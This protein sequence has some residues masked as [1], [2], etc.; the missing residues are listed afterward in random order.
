MAWE[1]F[2]R[3]GV[4][5]ITGDQP[6]DELA[7]ALAEIAK[8]YEER[9]SRKPTIIEIM[10]AMETVLGS[11]PTRYVSEERGFEIR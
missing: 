1:E 10:R 8:D 4:K 6:I 5:G 9:F 7:I 11:N 3:N 2:E